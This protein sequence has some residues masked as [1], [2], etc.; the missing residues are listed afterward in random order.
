MA[1]FYTPVLWSRRIF[2]GFV[3]LTILF[4][5]ELVPVPKIGQFQIRD[6]DS[7]NFAF[8][9]QFALMSVVAVN[10]LALAV[11]D[12]LKSKNAESL[13]LLLWVFGTFIFAGFINWSVNARSILPMTP[14]VAILIIRQIERRFNNTQSLRRLVWPLVPAAVIALAVCWADYAWAG[15]AREAASA[16]D[17]KFKTQNKTIWFQGHWGFQ[18]YMEAKNHKALDFKRPR[19]AHGD[20]LISPINNADVIKIPDKLVVLDQTLEFMPCRWCATKQEPLGAG[21]YTDFWGGVLPFA[22]GK[23]AT[24]KYYV[25]TVK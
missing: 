9:I 25:F 8:I 14:A 12:F 24:E 22:F 7:V 17:E 10:V 1:L 19:P 18:Y 2:F 5:F 6:A 20:I 11:I 16:I 15:T 21:F 4:I 23:V 3:I 13:L